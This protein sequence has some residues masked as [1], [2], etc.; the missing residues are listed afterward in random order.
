MK[1]RKKPSVLRFHKIKQEKDPEG[2]WFSEA[3]LY[4]PHDTEDDL[5]N[6]V[7]EVKKSQEM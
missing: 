5:N 2:F 4:I 1:L 6:H 7:M 3:M